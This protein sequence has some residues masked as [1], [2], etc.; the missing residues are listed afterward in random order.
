MGILN[1]EHRYWGKP[2]IVAEP[3]VSARRSFSARKEGANSRFRR[4]FANPIH[5]RRSVKWE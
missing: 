3:P 2:L 5:E 4:Y 1:E